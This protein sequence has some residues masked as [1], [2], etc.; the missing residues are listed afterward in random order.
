MEF[1]A[2]NAWFA[3]SLYKMGAR[4]KWASNDRSEQNS[5]NFAVMQ[6]VAVLSEGKIEPYMV[7]KS[8][9]NEPWQMSFWASLIRSLFWKE[10]DGT[11]QYPDFIYDPDG[12]AQTVINLAVEFE[13]DK[14]RAPLT[15]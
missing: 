5:D 11:I 12:I 7:K 15:P 4:V 13:K 6:A 14:H 1:N 3:L 10:A 2:V 8:K 9:K